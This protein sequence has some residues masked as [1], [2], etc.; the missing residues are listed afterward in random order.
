MAQTKEHLVLAKQVGVRHIVVFINKTDLA[1]PDIVSLVEM[2][3][4]ELLEQYGFEGF[5]Q[6]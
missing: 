5:F 6:N 4:L 1:D 3:A 2:E